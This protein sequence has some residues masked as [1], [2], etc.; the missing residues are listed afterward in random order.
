MPRRPLTTAQ[1][2]KREQ[3]AFSRKIQ[4]AFKNAGFEYLSTG[5]IE[6]Q[7]GSKTG[8]LDGIFLYENVLVVC[9]ETISASGNIKAH[10]INKSV[11]CKEIAE[12]RIE[13]LNWLKADFSEKFA[14][15]DTYTEP[16]YKIFF[17]YITKNKFN[18]SEADRELLKPMTVLENSDL[19]Y[20]HKLSQNI[21]L[22]AKNEFFRFLG[23]TRSDIGT[24]T[25]GD[26]QDK[27]KTTIICPPE[28]TGHTNGVRIVSFMMSAENLI[29]NS[30]VLRKDNWEN[31]IALYQRLIE[32]GRIQ[33][34]RKHLATKQTAFYNNIIVSLPPGIIFTNSAG[35]IVNLA[36]IQDFSERHVM[37]IPNELNSICVIDGQHRIFAHYEGIDNLERT[38]SSLRKKFH[39]LV[40][41]LIFPDDWTD[42]QR[43]KYEGEIFLDINS[44]A[45][46]V[47]PDVLLFI[48]TLKDPFSDL[49]I[50]RQVLE[51]LNQRTVFKNLF[52]MSLM[53]ES[54]IKI[55]SIIKFA[56][57]NLVDASGET[58]EDTLYYHWRQGGDSQTLAGS[59][60]LDLLDRYVDFCVNAL[61]IYFSAIKSIRSSDWNDPDSKILST[62]SINGFIMAL[63]R[64][65]KF[66]GIADN[67]HYRAQIEKLNIDFA[68]SA[69]PYTSSQYNKFSKQILSECFEIEEDSDGNWSKNTA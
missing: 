31:S 4:S 58:K 18:P 20:F 40:T 11:L 15:F 10:A 59:Q 28:T 17:V 49:G 65:L 34:I 5:D 24:I 38:I 6:R 30:Y 63:R 62:T 41:G 37:Q 26:S 51:K 16:R 61:D 19:N 27:I 57:R 8:E 14:R 68:K 52:Q 36:D 21:K 48:E 43:I 9:E 2:Q 29:N 44:N 22:S 13:L 45:R 23:L 47:P 53:E 7:F 56:L 3:N 25:S 32:K 12:N 69:F 64:S 55:A 46:P 67:A 66:D 54:T 33:S 35:E 42:Y 50:A 1:I 39:L 60:D